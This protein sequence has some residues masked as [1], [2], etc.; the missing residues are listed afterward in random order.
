MFRKTKN[1]LKPGPAQNVAK[2]AVEQLFTMVI[3]IQRIVII[4][5]L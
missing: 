1:G 2:K 4:V 5:W 3:L